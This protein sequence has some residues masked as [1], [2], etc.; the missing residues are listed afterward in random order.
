[1]GS[2]MQRVS[3]LWGNGKEDHTELSIG[4]ISLTAQGIRGNVT[5]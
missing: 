2:T 3:E 5:R 4:G 1:M